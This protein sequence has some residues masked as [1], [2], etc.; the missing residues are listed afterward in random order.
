MNALE[1]EAVR[2]KLGSDVTEDY[3]A[4]EMGEVAERYRSP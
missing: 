1:N 4:K 3:S 2:A